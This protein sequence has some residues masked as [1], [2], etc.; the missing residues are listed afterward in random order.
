MLKIFLVMLIFMLVPAGAMAA[1][2]NEI[3]I[4]ISAGGQA[5]SATLID[6]A[7]S[8][9]LISK[10]PLSIPMRDLY[11]REM[12]H[13]FE[14]PLP[15]SEVE[16]SGYEIGDIIYW[17]PRHSFVIMYEQNGERI[18]NLQKIGRIESGVELFKT[19]GD[20]EITLE[21]ADK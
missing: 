11:S 12:C 5:L 2:K 3:K 6:N 15:A 17:T 7:T 9:A 20:I 16:T 14:E 19:T 4:K 21:L 8:R 1:G 10:F 13:H 18:N